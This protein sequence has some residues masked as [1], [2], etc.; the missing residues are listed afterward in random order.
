MEKIECHIARIFSGEASSEDVLAVSDWLNEDAGRRAEFRLLESYWNARVDS[1]FGPEAASFERVIDKINARDARKRSLRRL[2]WVASSVAACVLLV[3]SAFLVFKDSSAERCDYYTYLA[4][5]SKCAITLDDGTRVVLNKHSRLT[6][7]GRYGARKRTVQ[8][9]GEAFFRVMPDKEHP[10]EVEMGDSKISVLGTAF[11]VKAFAG[12]DLLTA[13]LLEGSIRFESPRQKVVISPGQQLRYNKKGADLT[14][15]TVD[16]RYETS[17]KDDLV[18]YRSVRLAELVKELEAAYGI[19]IRL[20]Q[21]PR[22][23]SQEVS[24][25]FTRQQEIGEVLDIITR[26][27]RLQ[28]RRQG[29]DY[30]IE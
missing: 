24:G 29:S 5:D 20:P 14:V 13:T 22:I 3:L 15:E 28:W 6:C 16:V 18:Q 30:Y 25:A 17:W 8:L 4:G 2:C 11:A 9:N 21:D 1:V 12:Q 10:F 7:S 27:L 23:A 19:R 26:S